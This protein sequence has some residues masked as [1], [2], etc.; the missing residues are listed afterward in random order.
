MKAN[1]VALVT[2]DLW[3]YC[4]GVIAVFTV[5]VDVSISLPVC[6]IVSIVIGLAFGE[7]LR[8]IDSQPPQEKV[9]KV[10]RERLQVVIILGCVVTAGG[11][12]FRTLNYGHTN[13]PSFLTLPAFLVAFIGSACIVLVVPNLLY[14]YTHR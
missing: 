2:D 12:L 8:E 4:V 9:R 10:A 3:K 5:F 1:I 6:I 11:A 14:T 7:N 13:V